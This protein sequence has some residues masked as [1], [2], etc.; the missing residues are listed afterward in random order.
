MFNVFHWIKKH[1]ISLWAVISI[2]FA[3]IVHFA[4][5]VKAPF[6]WLIA[7]WSPGDILTY[8]GTVSLGLLAVWQNKQFKQENDK[9]QERLER[10]TI[11]ANELVIINKI[12][13]FESTYLNRLRKAFDEFSA[14]CD[15]Q[16]LA[17]IYAN[18]T[19][20]LNPA[21]SILTSIIVEEK[22]ID[23]SF[24]ELSRELRS[25]HKVWTNNNDPLKLS[26]KNYYSSAKKFI[27]KVKTSPME[28]HSA[29]IGTMTEAR[30]IFISQREKYLTHKEEI[31]KRVIYGNL[32]LTEIKDLYRNN[33]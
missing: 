20:S 15:P 28:N 16:V 27:D 32:T 14:T 12:I 18:N 24:F 23:D 33:Q 5:S 29:D 9:S 2:V 21:F 17:N 13:E 19:T 6:D 22:K 3:L 10:L 4:F 31:L 7:K 26:F 25:D 1:L 30:N 8:V 11:Q